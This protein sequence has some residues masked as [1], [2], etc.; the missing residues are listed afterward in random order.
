M[1]EIVSSYYNLVETCVFSFWACFFWPVFVLE[2]LFISLEIVLFC[3]LLIKLFAISFVLSFC[4][5]F[6]QLC[7]CALEC[8]LSPPLP[9]LFSLC[10]C[11]KR[12]CTHTQT[13]L[14]IRMFVTFLINVASLWDFV[15]L[16]ILNELKFYKFFWS[17]WINS[18]WNK[19]LL[20]L[21]NG[22]LVC[23]SLF[24]GIKLESLRYYLLFILV[25]SDF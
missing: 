21:S 24:M 18:Y 11:L 19:L 14:I 25:E 15:L 4:W 2:T 22:I 10:M 8:S 12:V 16:A 5:K 3:F 20:K 7:Q 17:C 13:L 6:D 9:L 23:I 1:I